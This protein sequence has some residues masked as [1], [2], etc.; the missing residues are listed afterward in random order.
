MTNKTLS[1]NVMFT[2]LFDKVIDKSKKVE[3]NDDIV[4]IKTFNILVLVSFISVIYNFFVRILGFFIA[5]YD[6]SNQSFLFSSSLLVCIVGC[7]F[8]LGKSQ[9]YQIGHVLLPFSALFSIWIYYPVTRV[10]IDFDLNLP[11][12]IIILGIMIGGLV[13]NI[14]Q[15]IVLSLC[16]IVDMIV[17]QLFIGGNIIDFLTPRILF[18][19]L[20]S[21]FVLVSTKFRISSIQILKDANIRLDEEVE[22]KKNNLLEERTILYGLVGNLK[23]GIIV[24]DKNM[25][26]LMVNS[27]FSNLF[28]QIIGDEYNFNWS[29]KENLRKHR[30]FLNIYIEIFELNKINEIIVE[31]KGYYFQVIKNEIKNDDNHENKGFLLEIH[32]ITQIENIDKIKKILS[33]TIVHE[34]RTPITSLSLS[35]NNLLIY[36]RSLTEEKKQSILKTMSNQINILS[37]I[38][39]NISTLSELEVNS[40]NLQ[41]VNAVK[42]VEKGVDEYALKTKN[43]KFHLENS[44]DMTIFIYIDKDSVKKALYHVL[45]NAVKF[46]LSKKE[47]IISISILKPKNII[48]KVKDYGIG[49]DEMDLQLITSKYYKA[50]NSENIQG[51]GLGLSLVKEIIEKNYGQLQIESQLGAG[52]T[53][54][55]ILPIYD[56]YRP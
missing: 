23:G 30:E 9:Y 21:I 33:R 46:S 52:T 28:K 48:I 42:F 19:V 56:I 3:N 37:N 13:L 39:E 15:Q 1:L 17:F 10:D 24:L 4:K 55:I 2:N 12:M 53:I 38:I 18:I 8:F 25:N 40:L 27:K 31:T 49:I 29:L 34:L 5:P 16:S 26:N 6:V 36:W 14:N 20:I 32:D 47:I 7:F 44:I 50:K 45:D 41:V 43:F 35:I 51:L 11:M 54:I 22:I